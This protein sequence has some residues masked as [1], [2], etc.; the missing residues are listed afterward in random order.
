MKPIISIII[1]IY[2]VEDHLQNCI[3]SVLEQSFTSFE[4]ILVNDGSQDKCGQICEAYAKKDSR[5]KV[6]HQKNKGVSSARNTGIDNAIGDYLAFI[7]PDDIILPNM[8]EVLMKYA[9]EY[10]ADVTV[11]QYNQKNEIE[12]SD[13]TPQVWKK[14]KTAIN[15]EEIMNEIFPNLLVNNTFS[16]IPC[17]NKLYKRSIFDIYHIRFDEYKSFG[18]DKQFNLNILPNI[19][20]LVFVNK[21]LYIYFKRQGESLSQVFRRDFY[22]YLLDDKRFLINICEKYN[23]NQY[24]TIINELF[25]TKVLIFIQDVIIN[26]QLSKN[27]KNDILFETINHEDFKKNIKHYKTNSIYYKTLKYLSIRKN[28]N[29]LFKLVFWK[30][31]INWRKVS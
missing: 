22:Y 1:P 6:F 24:I 27:I 7:D 21:P 19:G 20:T 29:Y 23:L 30:N 12:K 13:K 31:K 28:K 26:S 25:I 15:H 8:Y 16:L 10:T 11:C 18:E 17:F 4:L 2:N 5:I 14:T 9:T 3:D